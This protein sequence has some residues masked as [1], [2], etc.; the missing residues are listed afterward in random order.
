[1]TS[2][3]APDAAPSVPEFPA[4]GDSSFNSKAYTW[5]TW[6]PTLVTWITNVVADAYQNALSAFESATASAASAAA[7][8]A[9]AVTSM[10]G[11]NFKGDWAGLT[12][13]LNKPA[14]VAY[15][16]R[17]WLLLDNLADVTAA[18]PG[19]SA[20][21]LAFDI[22]LPVIP[23]TTA[24]AE[25]VSGKEYSV[26]YTGGQVT[27]KMPPPGIGAAVVIGVANKRSDLVLLHN[28][29]LFM[30]EL[31]LDDYTLVDPGRYAARHDGVSWRG[32][33]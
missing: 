1:M 4:L 9:S 3:V 14:S 10:A 7:S 29:G 15:A 19:V 12:G 33:A 11:S 31:A 16:G 18:V 28:G 32:L 13:V 6:L 2:P 30:D 21:W 22:L 27:L 8:E 23:V 20:S 17:V 5:G 26:L 24:Y 25:L